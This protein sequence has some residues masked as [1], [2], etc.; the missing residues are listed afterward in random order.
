[1]LIYCVCSMKDEHMEVENYI[2][3]SNLY[4]GEK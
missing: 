1:M 4:K 2:P 3:K